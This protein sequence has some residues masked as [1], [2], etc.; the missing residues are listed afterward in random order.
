MRIVLTAFKLW[1]KDNKTKKNLSYIDLFAGQGIYDDGTL[2]TPV[3]V[4]QEICETRTLTE[5]F[6]II[7]NDRNPEYMA[8][9]RRTIANV[10]NAKYIKSLTTSN[11]LAEKQINAIACRSNSKWT[12]R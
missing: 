1:L 12:A 7:L 5:K 3:R 10:R 8:K 9:L 2:S 4:L 11:T 6:D